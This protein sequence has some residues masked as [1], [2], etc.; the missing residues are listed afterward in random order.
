MQLL[1]ETDGL[2]IIL[3][4]REEDKQKVTIYLMS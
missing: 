4:F 1:V 3:G 2:K